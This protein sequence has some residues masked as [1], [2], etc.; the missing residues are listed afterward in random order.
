M[1]KGIQKISSFCKVN[2]YTQIG[3]R[4]IGA[5]QNY[6]NSRGKTFESMSHNST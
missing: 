1:E 4:I 3:E 2:V 6:K 5:A